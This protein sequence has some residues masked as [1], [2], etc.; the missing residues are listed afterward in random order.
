MLMPVTVPPAIALLTKA[1]FWRQ[2]VVTARENDSDGA[3]PDRGGRA[4]RRDGIVYFCMYLLVQQIFLIML[5]QS[6]EASAI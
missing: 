4:R 1:I 6:V 2:A 3:K 5:Y